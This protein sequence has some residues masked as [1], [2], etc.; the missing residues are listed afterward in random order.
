MIE[1]FLKVAAEFPDRIAVRDAVSSMTFAE[2]ERGTAGL[3]AAL[4][5]RGVGRG[6][7]VGVSMGRSAEVIVALLGIW[8]AGAAYVPLDPA[9]PEER[10]RFMAS[11]AGVRL[12]LTG[13]ME[14]GSSEDVHCGPADAAYVI[15]TSGSTGTPKG[16][17]GTFG[18]VA[19]LVDSLERAGIYAPEHRVVAWNASMS[20]DASIQQWAR[21]CRG[22]TIVV[23]SEEQRT[24]PDELAAFLAEYGVRD[25]DLTPS[26]WDLLGPALTGLP[27]RLFVGGEPVPEAMWR[28]LADH[29]MMEAVNLYGP[30]ECSVDATAAWFS[31][32][33]PHIGHPLPGFSAYVL[34]AALR[35]AG[36]GELYLAGPGVT[37]GYLRRP[38]MTAGRFLADLFAGDGTRMYRTGDRVRR[39]PDGALEFLGRVDRQVKVNGHRIELGE[40]EAAMTS[41]G[42][43]RAAVTVTDGQLTGYYVSTSVTPQQVAERLAAVLPAAVQPSGYHR[44][45]EFPLTVHGKIDFAA[46]P[47]SQEPRRG[48]DV[49]AA[50]TG[51]WSESLGLAQPLAPEADFFALGGSSRTAMRVVARI[52]GDL[53]VPLSIRELYRNPRLDSLIA[54]VAERV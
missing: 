14:G 34:D 39:R 43:D 12:I 8:R 35:P 41:V 47:V 26:H 45:E 16:V 44:L 23:L 29:P 5:E 4:R 2:L 36:E 15:Y 33:T 9:H 30:T 40:V 37:R 24:R 3:A 28:E 52:K 27:L 25:L 46:L 32:P 38:G 20:F 17:V 19:S 11:D 13:V 31:G 22:D 10:R 54:L 51:A 53:G 1:R 49:Y 21:V 18:G 7:H 50:I 42:V 48:V 6:D